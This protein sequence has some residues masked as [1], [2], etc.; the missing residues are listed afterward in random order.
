M[1]QP[2]FPDPLDRDRV[3]SDFCEWLLRVRNDISAAVWA[4][5]LSDAQ[6][7]RLCEL[8]TSAKPV[9]PKHHRWLAA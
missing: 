4:R 9:R 7:D 2:V 1:T 5:S 6:F 8:A 3:R